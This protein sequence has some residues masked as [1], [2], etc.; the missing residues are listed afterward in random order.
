MGT[1][2]TLDRAHASRHAPASRD[3]Q[4]QQHN[5]VASA[6]ELFSTWSRRV[7]ERRQLAK[8]ASDPRLL[9]DIGVSLSD[10]LHEVEKP[11]WRG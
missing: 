9:R 11:F 8:L 3:K 4:H 10:A 6:V 1:I 7:H 2:T 5:V